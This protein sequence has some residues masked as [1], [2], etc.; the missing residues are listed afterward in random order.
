MPGAAYVIVLAALGVLGFVLVMQYGFGIVPCHLCLWQR[1][2]FGIAAVVALIGIIAKPNARYA[3]LLLGLC[4]VLF[5]ADMGLAIFHT[6]VERHWWEWQ[7]SC[8]GGLMQHA[9]IDELREQLMGTPIVRCDEISWSVI[10]LSMANLNIA[11]C[12]VMALFAGYA[13]LR[14]N[15]VNR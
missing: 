5:L 1:V 3:S 6:G 2:P 10:G 12:F 7:S 13:S 15:K 11:F 9:S 14:C 4:A 8:T